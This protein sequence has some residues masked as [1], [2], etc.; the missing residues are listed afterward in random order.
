[1]EHMFKKTII[2]SI[3]AALI[4]AGLFVDP[5]AAQVTSVSKR[6]SLLIFP[7]IKTFSRDV[8]I[9]DTIV[10]IGNDSSTAT[11]VKCYWMDAAQVP[12][13]FEIYLTANQAVWFTAWQGW[14]TVD[15]SEFGDNKTG[16]LKCW[17]INIDPPA[18]YT[19][20]ILKK[21]NY[22][23]GSAVLV[24]SDPFAA[25]F[26]YQAWAFNLN[27]TPLA[28]AG[29]INL[30]GA[31]YDYCPA[32]LVYNFWA[33]G[34]WV[35]IDYGTEYPYDHPADAGNSYLSL[36][37]C[38]QDLRQDR[39]PVCTKAQ[40]NIWNENE[41]KF[42]GAYQCL[43]CYFEGTLTGIGAKWGSCDL[44]YPSPGYAE[45]VDKCKASGTGG[46]KFTFDVLHTD[47]GRLRVSPSLSTACNG[48]F[49][50]LGNDGK[51]VVDVCANNQYKSPFVGVLLT[52]L[53]VFYPIEGLGHVL[54]N[55]FAGTTG[56]GASQ[57]TGATKPGGFP[58][59]ILW[60]AGDTFSAKR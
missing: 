35:G 57:F 39:L 42:T 60:D 24:Q 11:W 51:T 10:T 28:Q 23:Y 58:P 19:T 13:D 53:E 16:E 18:P 14:G 47:L 54:P 29:P 30:D 38:Q 22:L 49:A 17:A 25:A 15:V 3:A 6:G 48:V 7:K 44:K 43:K 45:G 26:E 21:H 12:S 31:E 32:Y 46:N 33:Y 9:L 41:V 55:T 50:K 20:E 27:N 5:S 8:G 59:Q 40:F 2:F 56:T 4:M 36:S 1:M 34:G 52:D 37:P